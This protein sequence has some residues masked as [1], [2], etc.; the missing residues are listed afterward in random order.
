MLFILMVSGVPAQLLVRGTNLRW[1]YVF[2]LLFLLS[3]IEWV[4]LTDFPTQLMTTLD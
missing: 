2:G 1:R 4:E 3:S